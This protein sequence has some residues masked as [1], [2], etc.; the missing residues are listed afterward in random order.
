MIPHHDQFGQ[1]VRILNMN[2]LLQNAQRW[3]GGAI[4]DSM[5]DCIPAPIKQQAIAA[6]ECLNVL[7]TG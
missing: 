1:Q 6:I 4:G 5:A 2:Q 7:S 3:R